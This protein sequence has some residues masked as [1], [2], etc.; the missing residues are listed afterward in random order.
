[1]AD[2][3][4]LAQNQKAFSFSH[5]T[6]R[7]GSY[8]DNSPAAVSIQLNVERSAV[9]GMKRT[10][11]RKS[12]GRVA[13]GTGSITWSDIG[14]FFN[15]FH[16]LGSDP[17]FK[18]FNL[19]YFLVNN[20][21]VRSIELFGCDLSGFNMDHATGPDAVGMT[22]PFTFLD[23]KIDRVGLALSPLAL[24]Q[25]LANVANIAGQVF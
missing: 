19:D 2:F 10:P 23:G 1:M 18:N 11:L 7:V 17:L 5:A 16:S 25:S 22:V 6:L 15:F 4:P 12:D 8:L 24:I 3:Y 14:D 9:Y 20:G 21:D 13:M